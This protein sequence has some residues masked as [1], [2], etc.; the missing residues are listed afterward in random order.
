M[1]QRIRELGWIVGLDHN[2]VESY[3]IS[4]CPPRMEHILDSHRF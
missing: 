4:L 1:D 2:S 3:P